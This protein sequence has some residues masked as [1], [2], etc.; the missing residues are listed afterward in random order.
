MKFYVLALKESLIQL[1][2]VP[3]K[4]HGHYTEFDG[5]IIY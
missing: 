4:F 2:L 3:F 1:R 5:L